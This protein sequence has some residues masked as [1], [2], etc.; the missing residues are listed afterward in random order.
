MDS[1]ILEGHEVARTSLVMDDISCVTT[2]PESS[3][4]S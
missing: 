3:D 4:K 2:G 1:V